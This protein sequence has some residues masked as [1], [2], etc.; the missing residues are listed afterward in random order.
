M[1]GATIDIRFSS[2]DAEQRFLRLYLAAAWERYESSAYWDQGWYWAYG[3]L[4]PY[5]SGPE[6]G[7]VRLVFDG[8]PAGLVAAKSDQWDAFDGLTGW[9]C[10]RYDD[11]GFD[12]LRAQQVAAKGEVGGDWEYRYKPLT[13]RLALD[14]RREFEEPLPPSPAPTDDNPAGVGMFGLLHALCV[15][16]GYDW[17]E[18]TDT[19]LRGLQ[20]RLNSIA[21]YRGARAAREEYERLSEEWDAVGAELEAWVEAHETGA[22]SV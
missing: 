1:V 17:Y 13:S 6:G 10:R 14:Y 19:Y 7:L 8:D 11:E 5:D 16:S 22:E 12:S 20:N 21:A 2:S 18:E 4:S 15:Q 9:E 3:Q